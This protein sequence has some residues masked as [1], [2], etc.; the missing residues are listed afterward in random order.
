MEETVQG[1]RAFHK[2]PRGPVWKE[3]YRQRCLQRMKSSRAQLLDKYRRVGGVHCGLMAQEVMEM[4]WLALQSAHESLEAQRRSDSFV[5]VAD[6]EELEVLEEIQQE[7]MS[8][9]SRTDRADLP[10]PLRGKCEQTQR[11]VCPQA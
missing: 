6:P 8:Q 5:Q 1:R 9:G 10:S 2:R 4:E 7:L 11:D 3:T